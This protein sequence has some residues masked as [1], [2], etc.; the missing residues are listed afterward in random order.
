MVA[1]EEKIRL[2]TT[3]KVIKKNFNLD[4]IKIF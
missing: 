4:F 1:Q 2:D 3:Q